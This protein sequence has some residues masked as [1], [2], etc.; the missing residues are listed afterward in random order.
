[1]VGDVLVTMPLAIVLA[2]STADKERL[3]ETKE[4]CLKYKGKAVGLLK[5]PE[6]YAHRKEERCARQ[7]G[8]SSTNHP[9]VKV[10]DWDPCNTISFPQLV[11][12]QLMVHYCR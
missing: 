8:T 1:L 5:N 4:I 7:F 6:F 3:N 10:C 9:Y 11:H 2:V 12:Y